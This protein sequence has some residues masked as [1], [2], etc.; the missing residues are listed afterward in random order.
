[1]S[2]PVLRNWSLACSVAG[3]ALARVNAFG[4]GVR[5][6]MLSALAKS[7]RR[8]AR[9]SEEAG[10]GATGCVVGGGGVV[11]HGGDRCGVCDVQFGGVG[12]TKSACGDVEQCVVSAVGVRGDQLYEELGVCLLC[13]G[14]VVDWS[15]CFDGVEAVA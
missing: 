5:A 3:F 2:M 15:V 9:F 7:A 12:A 8:C 14:G 10:Y 11:V 6:G 13:R 4:F 1:A